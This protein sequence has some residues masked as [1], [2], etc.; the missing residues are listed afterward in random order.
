M[1]MVVIPA[2]S[3]RNGRHSRGD[4]KGAPHRCRDGKTADLKSEGWTED[5]VLPA[6]ASPGVSQDLAVGRR[7]SAHQQS[8]LIRGWLPQ[9]VWVWEEETI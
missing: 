2:L 8:L 5:P 9:R 6:T 4:L 1:A 7:R 3:T